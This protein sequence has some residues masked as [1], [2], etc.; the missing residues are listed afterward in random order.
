MVPSA[1]G[2]LLEVGSFAEKIT[3]SVLAGY[4][5]SRTLGI[6]AEKGTIELMTRDERDMYQCWKDCKALPNADWFGKHSNVEKKNDAIVWDRR[7]RDL[8]KI[9]EVTFFTPGK[10]RAWWEAL[11]ALRPLLIAF[12]MVRHA[13]FQIEHRTLRETLRRLGAHR[14]W[15]S[16]CIALQNKN[17]EHVSQVLR[18]RLGELD[19]LLRVMEVCEHAE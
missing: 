13:R 11:K 5:L 16:A 1:R 14:R 8:N 6:D 17:R 2:S 3:T 12:G 4:S 9:Y 18:T 10:A 7:A 19:K 15:V